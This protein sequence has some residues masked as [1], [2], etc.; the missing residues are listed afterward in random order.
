M[1][2]VMV[3]EVLV[4]AALTAEICGAACVEPPQVRT[5][6]E[7]GGRLRVLLEL[8]LETV[9]EVG[10]T[11][12][13]VSFVSVGFADVSWVIFTVPVGALVPAKFTG[14]AKSGLALITITEFVPLPLNAND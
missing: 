14:S 6:I 13:D 7:Y 8:K 5:V 9:V 2:Q 1:V 12:A 3:A 4:V 10:T 11:T